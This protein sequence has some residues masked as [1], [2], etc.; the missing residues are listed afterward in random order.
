MQILKEY[1]WEICVFSVRVHLCARV[2]PWQYRY[3]SFTINDH[4]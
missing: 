3:H 2:I 1:V 4:D